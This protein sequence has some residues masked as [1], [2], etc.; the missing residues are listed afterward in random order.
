MCVSPDGFSLS[1]PHK[2]SAPMCYELVVNSTLSFR[3]AKNL[4][5]FLLIQLLFHNFADESSYSYIIVKRTLFSKLM[6]L[7]CALIAGS[8]SVWATDQTITLTYRSFGLETSYKEKTATV[9]GF[10]FTVDQGYKGSGNVIQMD[11]SKGNG[12]LY[13]TTSIPGLKS[14][15]VNVSSGNKTYT[16]TT[17]TSEKP[18]AN[19]Q[20][21]TTGG[22]YNAASGDSYF[23]LKVSGA[24]YFSSIEITSLLSTKIL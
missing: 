20:T 16:I 1:R 3:R 7:L 17:G 6:L 23:Q 5:H 9:S 2:G 4:G 18:S 8:S 21:G 19:S 14:I 13:N 11:S 10:G 24:S 12:I 15:K 22:T